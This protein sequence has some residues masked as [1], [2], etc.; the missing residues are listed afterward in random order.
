MLILDSQIKLNYL[1][2]GTV[3]V[4]SDCKKYVLNIHSSYNI[5]RLLYLTVPVSQSPSPRQAP[6]F[7][8]LASP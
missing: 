2:S 6:L 4:F 8:S 7:A 3:Y 1:R 5:S